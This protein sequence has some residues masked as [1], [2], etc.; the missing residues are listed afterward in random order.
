MI[1]T[2]VATAMGAIAGSGI[3]KAHPVLDGGVLLNFIGGTVG[4]YLGGKWLSSTATRWFD[5]STLDGSTMI[6]TVLAGAIGGTVLAIA[7]AFARHAVRAAR[8]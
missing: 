4:G 5:G 8:S 6:G 7:L 1:E 3:P 2:I